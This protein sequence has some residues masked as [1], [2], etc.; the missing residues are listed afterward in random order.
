MG[1]ER[2]HRNASVQVVIQPYQTML[3]PNQGVH[4]S[5]TRFVCSHDP[6]LYQVSVDFMCK[7]YT[8]DYA[9]HSRVGLSVVTS[10][11]YI[12]ITIETEHM[13]RSF[14]HTYKI[15]GR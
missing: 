1:A 6:V 12:R 2:G 8:L 10:A 15:P 14:V 4:H 5:C 13:I 3:Q 11:V 9:V 7:R